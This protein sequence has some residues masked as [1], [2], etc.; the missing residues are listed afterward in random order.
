MAEKRVKYP[1]E[2]SDKEA[3]P[4]N[5]SDYRTE[6]RAV[7]RARVEEDL[8]DEGKKAPDFSSSF[9]EMRPCLSQQIC[10]KI[11]DEFLASCSLKLKKSVDL[12]RY[13]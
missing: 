9:K 2:T 4:N 13:A 10:S 11:V 6:Q 1:T 3:E 12:E 8:M 7:A 5:D